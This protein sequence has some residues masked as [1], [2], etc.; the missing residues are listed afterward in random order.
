M[1]LPENCVRH[2]LIPRNYIC[3]DAGGRV[4]LAKRSGK[5]WVAAPGNSHPA[6]GL[7][8][9]FDADTLTAVAAMVHGYTA[10]QAQVDTF[11]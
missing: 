8:K 10:P 9:W 6:R 5:G 2:P 3:Y 7:G 1:R 4:W 11:A